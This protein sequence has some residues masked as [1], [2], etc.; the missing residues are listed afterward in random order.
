MDWSESHFGPSHHSKFSN[1]TDANVA[2][3]VWPTLSPVSRCP[4]TINAI[5]FCKSFP[6]RAV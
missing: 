2:A 3:S 1:V 4:F 5:N 6:V